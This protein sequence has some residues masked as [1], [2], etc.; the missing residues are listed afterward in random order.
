MKIKMR[1]GNMKV[2]YEGELADFY[3]NKN[4]FDG[5]FSKANM[6]LLNEIYGSSAA[7]FINYYKDYNRILGEYIQTLKASTE[8]KP[9][10]I[11]ALPANGHDIYNYVARYGLANCQIQAVIKL[12]GHID[13]DKLSKAVRLSVDAEPVF[14]C[15]FIECEKPYW[16]RLDNIKKIEFCSMEEPENTD[17]AIQSFLE[18]P[19]DMDHDPMVKVKLIRSAQYDTLCVKNNHACC[20]GAGTKEYI[21][22]LSEL[23]SFLDQDSGVVVPKP[24]KRGRKEQDQLFSAFG[25][26]NPESEWIP[27]SEITQA[28]WPF[29]WKQEHSDKFQM[30]VCRLPQ[31]RLDE[32]I[33]YSKARNATI[34]DLVLTAYYRAMSEVSSPIYEV[35][36][37]IPVTVDLRRHLPSRRT[38]AIRN[39]SGSEFTRITLI[40]NEAFPETLSRVVPMMNEIKNNRP[41]LQSAIGLE[42]VEKMSFSETVAYYK[43]VSQWP[44]VCSDKCAP[45]LSNV[46]IVADSLLQF[47]NN[48]ATDAY[49]IPPVVRLPGLLLMVSTYN[50]IITLAAGFYEESI[51]RDTIVTLLDSIKNE[52]IE[53]CRL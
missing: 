22:L 37:E 17:E 19:L 11:N 45:V 23:Y 36:M 9:D 5:L 47:G 7:N 38:E 3:K 13:F 10:F 49:I 16:R 21:Q 46:G 30:V 42:R 28:T 41:G 40:P 43:T 25:I 20:D 18:S 2:S 50:G 8:I 15:R 31:G 51:P 27:G 4:M 48:F 39:F 35:P 12:D 6:D 24:R 53:G 34:N 26:K 52:L 29:P 1:F 33:P 32:M 14:G 44:V